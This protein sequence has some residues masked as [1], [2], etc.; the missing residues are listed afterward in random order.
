[1]STKGIEIFITNILLTV[2]SAFVVVICWDQ[3]AYKFEF[4]IP[5]EFQK[6]TIKE[7][8]CLFIVV[9]AIVVIFTYRDKR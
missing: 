5:L 6:W 3:I 8:V 2:I 1:M 4:L 7:F 9:R